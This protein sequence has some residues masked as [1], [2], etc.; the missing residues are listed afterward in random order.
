MGIDKKGSLGVD[1]LAGLDPTESHDKKIARYQV[2]KTR[3]CE[4]SKYI[5]SPPYV[6]DASFKVV[7]SARL[8]AS[9]GVFLVFRHYYTIGE[10]RMVG[11]RFC[12]KHLYCALC[13]IRRAAKQLRAYLEKTQI[14]LA[15]HPGGKLVF[16]TLTVRNGEDL[17][18]RFHHLKGSW[19]KMV[20]RRNNC[21]K[22]LVAETAFA[23]FH[24]AVAT[25]ELTNKGKGW[26]PHIHFIALVDHGYDCGSAKMAL[27]H[28]W[29]DL[30]GDSDQVDIRDITGNTE[31]ARLKAFV[32]VFKYPLK[33]ND[34]SMGHQAEAAEK[35]HGKRL[36]TAFGAFFGVKVPED[37][38]DD[39]EDLD[40]LPYIEIV[41]RFSDI[42]GYQ[43]IE[44]Q[45]T[46][47]KNP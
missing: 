7:K 40:L 17:M 15:D 3:A 24:G 41:Y 10:Y 13:A 5:L 9:C 44:H 35:L 11:N 23:H 32:E 45:E 33:L 25:Y 22:G 4:L 30:T 43:I 38:N 46:P 47:P 39:V 31:E 26:H 20:K 19:A 34:M 28:E 42:S 36:I 2:A 14:V 37:L 6:N 16:G 1:E 29:H 27:K 12:Q 8:V 21:Q 18:E